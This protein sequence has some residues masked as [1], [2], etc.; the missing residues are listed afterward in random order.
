VTKHKVFIS[1]HHGN[2]QAYKDR[3][4][5]LFDDYH[6][7]FIDG[8][9]S[10]GDISDD[11]KTETIRQTIRDNYLRN[12]SVTL[13]LI[14]TETWKRKHVDWEISSSLRDT[15]FNPRSGLLGILLP[16]HPDYNKEKYYYK[17]IPPRLADNCKNNYAQ[18]YNWSEDPK[19]IMLWIDKAFEDKGKITP[20][21]S[22]EMFGKNRT[23][24][25]WND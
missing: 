3:F 6:D 19:S 17:N 15:A 18:I 11:I 8:S 12:T 4:V 23:G 21:N 13:V 14:G 5:K 22:R 10:D 2:D 25:S 7:V 20:D 9:V 16:T 24:E 1:Y